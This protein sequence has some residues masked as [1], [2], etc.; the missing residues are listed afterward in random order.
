MRY[1]GARPTAAGEDRKKYITGSGGVSAGQTV[2]NVSYDEGRAEAYLNGVRLFPDSDFTR[3]AS[4]V[5]TNITLGVGVGSNDVLEL[6]GWQGVHAGNGLVEDRFVVGTGST[7]SGGSYTNSTTVFPVSS[8]VGDSVSVWRNGVKL[9]H[10]TDFTVAPA[11][12][13]VTL[14]SAATASDEICVQVVG[15]VASANFIKLTDLIDEDSFS[16]NSAT[17]VPSQQS[18][19]SYIDARAS[20]ATTAAQGVGTG[21]SPTF[22]NTTLTGYLA[23][24]ASFT[25]DPATVGDNTGT[26]VI[27]GNL[28]VD[29]TTTTV[30]STTMTVDDLNLTLASG[31][32]NSAAANGAGLTIDGASATML[33]THATT[34]FDFNKT[35]NATIGTAAQ[36]NITS[37]GTLTSLGLSGNITLADDTSIGISDSDERIE[38]DASGDISFLGANVGIG[39]TDPSSFTGANAQRLVVGAGTGHDGMTIYSSNTDSGAI[40]FADT[41][42][43]YP[44]KI[45][46]AHNT[47]SMTFHTSNNTLAMTIDSNQNVSINSGQ[48][49]VKK[50]SFAQTHLTSSLILGY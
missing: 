21:N 10:T 34:S 19:K 43:A 5:G 38:F 3:T 27:A 32:A 7:G 49:N 31:A 14:T 41:D 40:A 4:G 16:T 8:N 42:H 22:V 48:L 17:K 30:N 36:P 20:V 29:G 1:I 23:G 33:Y 12:S 44:G 46:Y 18:T 39:N 47:G 26:L 28:Q 35:V 13:T 45:A 2:F 11:S 50:G 24:P 9:V 37:L 25:I 6:V 15:I